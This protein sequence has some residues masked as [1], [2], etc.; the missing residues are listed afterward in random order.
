MRRNTVLLTLF[1]VN[2]FINIPGL[3]LRVFQLAVVILSSFFQLGV[4]TVAWCF[5]LYVATRTV[6]LAVGLYT[7]FCLFM[8][9]HTYVYNDTGI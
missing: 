7:R 2:F 4:V 9:A 1:I 8:L 6:P 5:C 3:N